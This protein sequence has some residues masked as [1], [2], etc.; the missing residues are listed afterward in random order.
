MGQLGIGKLNHH[1]ESQIPSGN[2]KKNGPG[3]FISMVS[4]FYSVNN[5]NV[6]HEIKFKYKN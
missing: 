6:C 3:N 4:L 5:F 2:G 1:D